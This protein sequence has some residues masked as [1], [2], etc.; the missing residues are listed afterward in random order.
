[1]IAIKKFKVGIL[2]CGSATQR[3]MG[4]A[5]KGSAC[6]ELTAVASRDPA[7]AKRYAGQ[8]GCG[9]E[10]SYEDLLLRQDLDII[11]ISLPVSHHAEWT[12]RALEAGK[13][14]HCEKTLAPSLPEVERILESAKRNTKRVM[15]G[16][17]Y[18]F[19][20]L[21]LQVK[22]MLVRGE[23]GELRS[24]T[25]SFGF[26]LPESDLVR[27][28]PETCMG[29]LNE[30][31][32]YA[33]SACRLFFGHEPLSVTAQIEVRD[34]VEF[35]GHATFDFGDGRS[36]HCEF[37]FER[38]YRCSYNLWGTKSQV[39]VD[40]AFTPPPDFT[41]IIQWTMPDGK[42]EVAVA[43]ANHFSLMID[44]FCRAIED[45]NGYGIFEE[46]ALAQAQVME[47]V[48]TSARQRQEII[49]N[50]TGKKAVAIEEKT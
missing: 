23:L 42:K 38:S 10:Q 17:M 46:E 1:M 3:L 21:S 26:Q 25:G 4:P 37:G 15:E 5:F 19:H 48:R 16:L 6:A 47:A 24:F 40:R 34:A 50:P 33:V 14:V 11:Y 7:K 35:S 44:A 30:S 9:Y 8:L 39:F 22:S 49:L 29:A 31:G 41:S 13:H 2:G 36:G 28:N 43:P 18:R 12:I 32:C 45:N 27:R 20:P